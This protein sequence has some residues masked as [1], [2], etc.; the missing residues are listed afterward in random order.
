MMR[1]HLGNLQK[2]G[3]G[4][5]EGGKM[6]NKIRGWEGWTTESIELHLQSRFLQLSTA[7]ALHLYTEGF[8]TVEDIYNILQLSNA[9]ALKLRRSGQLPAGS[10]GGPKPKLMATYYSK[11]TT[12]FW[13]SENHLFHAFAWYKY[14]ALCTECNKSMTA[15][16]KQSLASTVLLSA[17]CIPETEGRNYA[18][19]N[20]RNRKSGSAEYMENPVGMLE[21]EENLSKEK[22]ARMATLLGFHT[23]HP[24]REVLLAELKAVDILSDVP[25]YQRVVHVA[26]REERCVAFG[27]EGQAVVDEAQKRDF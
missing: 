2:Y 19:Q 9:H 18:S 7:S 13:V 17:L 3:S 8:R 14:H 25:D 24:T 22:M 6:N 20:R 15:A 11:L 5:E 23:K 12:L 26:R 21:E 4:A 27:Q 16:Q 10:T 1:Q